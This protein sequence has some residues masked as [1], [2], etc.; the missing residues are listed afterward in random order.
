MKEIDRASKVNPVCN[1]KNIKSIFLNIYD[2]YKKFYKNNI[3][4]AIFSMERIFIV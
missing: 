1:I 3:K 4:I 2:I